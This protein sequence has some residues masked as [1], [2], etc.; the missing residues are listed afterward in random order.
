MSLKEVKKN[1]INKK[2]TS[3]HNAEKRQDRA[4]S[5]PLKPT[6]NRQSDS[7]LVLGENKKQKAGKVVWYKGP[8]R[9]TANLKFFKGLRKVQKDS[10]NELPVEAKANDGKGTNLSADGVFTRNE[11]LKNL[12]TEQRRIAYSWK[13]TFPQDLFQIHENSKKIQRSEIDL[14]NH[15]SQRESKLVLLDKLI[16]SLMIKGKQSTAQ[17]IVNRC[18]FLIKTKEKESPLKFI[19]QSIQNVKPL[20]ELEKKSKKNFSSKKS[21]P[22]PIPTRRA[23]KLAIEWLIEGAK[24]RPER[25]LATSLYLELTNAYQRKGYAMKKKEEMHNLCKN[26]FYKSESLRSN[27]KK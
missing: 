26:T 20:I 17:K 21:K 10:S 8:H 4:K 27:K 2:N 14:L 25:S 13:N 6:T 12:I 23:I 5:S 22:I 3:L 19:V 16:N 11:N 24:Q 15:L 1:T 9:P 7:S 18:Y